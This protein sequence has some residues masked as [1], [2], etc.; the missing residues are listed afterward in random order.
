MC[1]CVK[2]RQREGMGRAWRR[3]CY[4]SCTSARLHYNSHYY[5]VTQRWVSNYC[6]AVLKPLIWIN[7]NFYC[8][9]FNTVSVNWLWLKLNNMVKSC[10]LMELSKLCYCN[11]NSRVIVLYDNN[12]DNRMQ[13][14][15]VWQ[16][17]LTA[18][19]ILQLG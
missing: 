2:R 11:V 15:L 19:C 4:I 18:T 12:C 13:F 6:T 10:S 5:F 8:L 17:T 14:Y 9:N 1:V 3:L 16:Q 7:F